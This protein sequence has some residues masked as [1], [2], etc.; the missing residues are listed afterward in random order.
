MPPS[1]PDYGPHV[2][3]P[4]RAPTVNLHGTCARTADDLAIELDSPDR[5]AAL[6]RI[7]HTPGDFVITIAWPDEDAIVSSLYGVTQHHYTVTNDEYGRRLVHA[8][9]VLDVISRAGLAW[10]WNFAAL[11]DLAE[12]EY[13][14]DDD[15][16]HPNVRRVP[17]RSVLRFRN[18]TLT[19]TTLDWDELHPRRASTPREAADAFNEEVARWLTSDAVLS[20]S[21]G[22]DSRVMLGAMLRA[23]HRPRCVVMGNAD[24]T[25]VVISRAIANKFDLDLTQIPVYLNDYPRVGETV[26]AITNGTKPAKH[27]HTYLYSS[28]A[29]LSCNTPL[30]V[31]T[32]GEFAR[33]FLLDGGAPVRLL[34]RVAP[35]ISGLVWRHRRNIRGRTFFRHDLH[36]LRPELAEQLRPGHV[37]DRRHRRQVDLCTHPKGMLAG[38]DRYYLSHQV[39]RFGGNGV[40]LYQ[41]SASCVMPFVCHGWVDAIWNL[42]AKWKMGSRWHRFALEQDAPALLDFPCDAGTGPTPVRLPPFYYVP[43]SGPRAV[44]YADYRRWFRHPDLLAHIRTHRDALAELVDPDHLDQMLDD[45][46]KTGRRLFGV[47][48]LMLMAAWS[49]A[50]RRTVA[51]ASSTTSD[52][53]RTKLHSRPF[54]AT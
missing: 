21:G 45:H 23:G 3:S 38:L 47:S 5:Q 24:S 52:Q 36:G 53:A 16:L 8:P 32:A 17:P 51:N 46:A 28:R 31:G 2:T 49:A 22:L 14:L 30:F 41:A 48:F 15:T 20:I 9:T 40:A 44:P 12:L 13:L 6:E 18:G 4:P 29:G 11:A 39:R 26:A 35:N 25:D 37:A 33:T 43:R 42:P 10:S 1:P 50:R 34:D 19:T 27:W 54:G 7:V